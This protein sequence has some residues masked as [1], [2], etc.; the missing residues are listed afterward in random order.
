MWNEPERPEPWWQQ[1]GVFIAA[2]AAI[3]LVIWLFDSRF[4]AR[5]E[6]FRNAMAIRDAKFADACVARNGHV[7]QN[8]G[9]CLTDD[10]RI[11]EFYIDKSPGY[12]QDGDGVWVRPP[13][14]PSD[15]LKGSNIPFC[16]SPEQSGCWEPIMRGDGQAIYR[17]KQ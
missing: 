1:V 11:V 6:D 13:I 5:S 3:T 14:I 8:K 10:G 9:F 16:R 12:V 17:P 2:V 7:T 15:Q 4:T